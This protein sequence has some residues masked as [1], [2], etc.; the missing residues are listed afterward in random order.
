MSPWC[1]MQL[2]PKPGR[3][4]YQF[5]V[6]LPRLAWV[7]LVLGGML[8]DGPDPTPAPRAADFQTGVMPI[9]VLE[10]RVRGTKWAA[11]KVWEDAEPTVEAAKDEV[12]AVLQNAERDEEAAHAHAEEAAGQAAPAEEAEE[13]E[14]SAVGQDGAAASGG[15]SG[16]GGGSSEEL[17]AAHAADADHQGQQQLEEEE[18]CGL[19]SRTE[20][21]GPTFAVEE[22]EDSAAG[23]DGAAASGGHSGPGGSSSEELAAAHAAD[24]DHQGQQ[25]QEH[26]QLEEAGCGLPSR[27]EPQGPTFAVEEAEDSAAASGQDGAA[28]SGGHGVPRGSSLQAADAHH[29]GPQQQEE[30]CGLPTSTSTGASLEGQG[31]AFATGNGKGKIP[32]SAGEDTC[33]GPLHKSGRWQCLLVGWLVCPPPPPLSLL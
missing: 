31:P 21:Q 29:Q 10:L 1:G 28:A 7:S 33:G 22:A 32:A 18:G 30:D 19:P 17:A 3:E 8:P 27:T 11:I 14:D 9:C 12:E 13:A 20:P 23:Q 15:H 5:R 24:A 4:V 26:Q 6:R 25:Q 2:R 16:P